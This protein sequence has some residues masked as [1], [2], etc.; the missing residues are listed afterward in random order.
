MKIVYKV[1][2]YTIMCA[3]T[4]YYLP[5]EVMLPFTNSTRANCYINSFWL[6]QWQSSAK[7]L[8]TLV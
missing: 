2:K 4:S 7:A 6:K 1:T 8:L 3:Q 5:Q